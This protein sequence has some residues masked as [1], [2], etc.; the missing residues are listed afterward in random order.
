MPVT[1]ALGL[2]A[3]IKISR[4]LPGSPTQNGIMSSERIFI[5]C[6]DTNPQP[7]RSKNV[8]FQIA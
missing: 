3:L 5:Y 2:M 8:E 6:T 1:S 4:L 7:D